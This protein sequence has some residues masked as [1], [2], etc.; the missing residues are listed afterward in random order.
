VLMGA[1]ASAWA[2]FHGGV[3]SGD[4]N[5]NTPNQHAKA[6]HIQ[7]H[8]DFCLACISNTRFETCHGR[9]RMAMAHCNHQHPEVTMMEFVN[10]TAA[11]EFVAADGGASAELQAILSKS[12]NIHTYAG[13]A[14]GLVF[15]TVAKRSFG[16]VTVPV[17]VIQ[18]FFPQHLDPNIE[19][20]NNAKS[21]GGFVLK[22][23]EMYARDIDVGSFYTATVRGVDIIV[24]VA[25]C[26]VVKVEDMD[27]FFLGCTQLV[28]TEEHKFDNY[29]VLQMHQQLIFPAACILK[30]AH[31]VHDCTGDCVRKES[32]RLNL[33]QAILA[34]DCVVYGLNDANVSHN[35]GN[36]RY[37]L[38]SFYL[39]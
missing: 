32:S 14:E 4:V 37:L 16:D 18:E 19:G 20:V 23:R 3:N 11:L 24:K 21:V 33:D 2:I 26:L 5:L 34:D 39:K 28:A 22:D 1:R 8:L 29:Q 9:N 38:N 35:Y 7:S 27:H 36:T 12:T 30:P 25:E 15:N 10:V 31:V 13:N 6:H 17:E